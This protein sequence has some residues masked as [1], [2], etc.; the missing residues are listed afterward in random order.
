MYRFN[1]KAM[2]CTGCGAAITRAIT[3]ADKSARVRA[4]PSNHRLEVETAL[5]AEQLL[6]L[7]D[8]AGYPAEPVRE[9]DHE[10]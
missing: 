4:F 2:T 7:L 1:V 5:S 3:A 10:R 8:D 9:D 6:R